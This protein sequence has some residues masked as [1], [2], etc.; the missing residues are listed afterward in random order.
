MST[1]LGMDRRA[2]LRNTGMAALA[3]AAGAGTAR[4]GTLPEALRQ[5]APAPAGGVF[6]FDSPC[7]RIGSNCVKWDRQIER[8]GKNIEVGMGIADMDFHAAPCISRALAERC[9]HDNWGYLGNTKSYVDAIVAWNKRRH[10]L[11]VDP[12]GIVLCDGVHP[13]VIAALKTFSPPGSRV[14]LTTPTY[15]GF[16]G[17]L[18]ASFTLPMD[19]P[20]TCV[21]GKY[22]IDFDDLTSRIGPDTH[23]LILCNPQN[24]TGNCWSPDDLLKLGRLCLERRVVVLADEIFADLVMTGQTYTPFA[25]LPDKDVVNNSVTFKAISKTFSLAAMKTAYFFST[26]RAFLERIQPNHRADVN[27]LGVVAS[28]AA[29][30]EGERWLDQLLPYLSANHDF[31]ESYLRDRLPLVKYA[32]AQGTYL[33]WLDVSALMAKIGADERAAVET[34]KQDR[35]LPPVTPEAVLERWLVEHANVHMNTGLSYGTGGAGHMRMNLGTSRRLI[36]KA[37]DNI[38]AAVAAI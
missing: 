24:P 8:F 20:M 16:Y 34:K 27:T 10:R 35:S 1:T 25:S 31:V 11:D 3:G 18:R 22:A 13:G 29:Y 9:R 5:A 33:A 2:F 6:D 36:A 7:N 14:L 17:D 21:G 38:A 23:T 15:N 12:D 19:S 26:N 28:E 32:K 30:R 37:L 4:A